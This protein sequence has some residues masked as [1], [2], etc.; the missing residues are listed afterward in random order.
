MQ[1]Q[2]CLISVIPNFEGPFEGNLCFFRAP[3]A[4]VASFSAASL[5]NVLEHHG[6]VMYLVPPLQ[7]V[8]LLG[9]LLCGQPPLQTQLVQ[10]GS[11]EH[12]ENTQK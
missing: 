6:G 4:Q 11:E 9:Q 2:R 12:K 1:E 5:Q 7:V 8:P 3:E 10:D